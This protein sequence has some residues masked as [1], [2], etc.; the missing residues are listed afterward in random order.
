[1]VENDTQNGNKLSSS[2]VWIDFS[3]YLRCRMENFDSIYSAHQIG[4]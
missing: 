3:E 4:G 2:Q 1:M